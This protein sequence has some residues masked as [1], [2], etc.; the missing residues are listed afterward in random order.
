MYNTAE[1]TSGD[2]GCTTTGG[3]VA[4]CLIAIVIHVS[5]PAPGNDDDAEI[6]QP[7]S[8]LGRYMSAAVFV[9]HATQC[10]CGG[11]S[12]L[13]NWHEPGYQ[14]RKG[15]EK[16]KRNKRKWDGN[17]ERMND[18]RKREPRFLSSKQGS[19]AALEMCIN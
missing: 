9:H 17:Q 1:C 14:K 6:G 16:R 19:G 18:R 12:L 4:S 2:L 8:G 11:A 13:N 5:G 15:K 10:V 3:G 7:M